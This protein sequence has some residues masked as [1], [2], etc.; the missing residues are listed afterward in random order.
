MASIRPLLFALTLPA[1]LIACG[2]GGEDTI[3]PE[4]EHYTYVASEVNLPPSSA[5]AR[6]FSLDLNGD[7]TVDNS[8]GMVLSTLAGQGFDVQ[9]TVDEAVATG[10]VVL[11]LDFQTKDFSSAAASGL[12]VKLGATPNPAACNAGEEYTCNMADPPVCTGCGRHLAGGASFTIAAGSPDNAAVAGKVAGGTFTGGPGDI[13]LQ[14]ALAEMQPITLGLIGAR[15]KATG[16]SATAMNEVIVAGAITKDD[17]DNEIIPAIAAQLPPLIDRDCDVPSPPNPPGCGCMAESTGAT[18][19][20]FFDAEPK[21]CAVSVDEIKTN[22]LIQSL[23]APDVTIEGKQA[24]SLGLKLKAVSA[25][26]PT[27]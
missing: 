13:S 7:G 11:L 8:L 24:L 15:A 19:L 23:L 21:D 22:A 16:I 25:T 12:A 1:S 18:I 6:D 14:I 4:G 10:S 20:N 2:G 17:I 3:V 27:E 5:T 9:G 26:F